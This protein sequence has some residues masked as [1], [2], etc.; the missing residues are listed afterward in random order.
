MGATTPIERNTAQWALF[1]QWRAATASLL[2]AA[3]G[4]MILLGGAASTTGL[5]VAALPALPC[6][7]AVCGLAGRRRLAARCGRFGAALAMLVAI[8]LL[9][10][11][12]LL[13]ATSMLPDPTAGAAWIAVAAAL[14]A[15]AGTGWAAAR[16]IDPAAASRRS[17]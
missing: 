1:E 7:A 9:W 13:S 17:R 3:C 12:A 15:S 16:A 8:L 4:G 6:A 11:I 5:W 10:V 2:A 14:A